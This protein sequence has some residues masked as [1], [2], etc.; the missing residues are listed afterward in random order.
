MTTLI[1]PEQTRELQGMRGD[2]DPSDYLLPGTY[3][4]N[5]EAGAA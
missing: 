4:R 5:T 3:R 2:G 1:S